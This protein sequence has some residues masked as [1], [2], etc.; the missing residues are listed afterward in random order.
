MFF[1]YPQPSPGYLFQPTEMPTL[2]EIGYDLYNSIMY[3]V[4]LH[5][6]RILLASVSGIPQRLIVEL[7]IQ[8]SEAELR[9]KSYRRSK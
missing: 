7:S 9:R 6:L 4:W 1:V 2:V 8:V 5:M 3:S